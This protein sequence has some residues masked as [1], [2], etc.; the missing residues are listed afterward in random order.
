MACEEL[1]RNNLLSRLMIPDRFR[2]VY[3]QLDTLRRC[4][5]SSLRKA[6][7]E[8]PITLD[9]TYERALKEIP[10]EKQQ[11]AHRLFQ[12]L[13]AAIRPLRAEELAEIFAIDF[14]LKSELSLLEDWRPVNPEEAVLSACSTLISIIEDD[15][16]KIVQFSHFSVKEFLISDRLQSS[17]IGNTRQ[18]HIPLDT[19]HAVLARACLTVLLQLDENVDKKFLTRYPLVSYAA[20]QWFNHV[21]FENVA[22]RF[23]DIL[24]RLFNPEMPYL[25]AWVWVH[26]VDRPWSRR[27]INDL[28]E[29]PPAPSA[30][31]LYYAALYGFTG[32]AKHLIVTHPEDVNV[33]CG[34]R[35]SPLH[36]A[37]YGGHLDVAQLL[38]ENGANINLQ[39]DRGKTPLV[40]AYGGNDNLEAMRLLLKHGATTD[41]LYIDLWLILHEA[42]YYG[43]VGVMELLLQHNADVNARSKYNWTPLIWASAGGCV[44]A[45][46]LLLEHGADINAQSELHGTSLCRASSSGHLDIVRVLLEHG[47]DVHVR[48]GRDRTAF[49]L[50]TTYGHPEIA[51]LLL[52]HGA[53][54]EGTS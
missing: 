30:T 21:K 49:Q 44:E 40:A 51:K 16:S 41:I 3:C 8:L 35:G 13:V 42:S 27:G 1:F 6:L 53:E 10:K 5:P 39:D 31:A 43:P 29:H 11:H 14:D 28:P 23:E 22:S 36:A 54:D 45:V 7:N 2:W 46:Q 32:L 50:A 18:Y 37:S 24:E 19:A 25:A 47:A 4:M 17:G 20:E 26:D 48:E 15:G 33:R 52:E 34:E 12:C 9:D 38:L